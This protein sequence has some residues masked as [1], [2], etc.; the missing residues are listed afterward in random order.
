MAPA[1]EPPL[2][3]ATAD[4]A[5]RGPYGRRRLRYQLPDLAVPEFPA[6]IEV[7]AEVTAP[8][9]RCRPMP[10]V[11]F[12]HGRHSTCYRGGP[13]GRASGDWPCRRAGA[14]CRATP[15]YRYIADVLASQGYLTVSIS[16]NGIN[17]QDGMFKDGGAFA[18]SEL[19]RHHLA[20]W[21]EWSAH[22]GDPWGGPFKAA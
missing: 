18:R 13:D 20:Q 22:G 21:A 17:G 15:G 14:R 11:L 2:A 19:V 1:A 4:P 5:A 9:G 7:L 12:L 3:V 8:V 16:A 10:L 6:P